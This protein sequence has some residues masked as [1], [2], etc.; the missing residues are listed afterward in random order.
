MIHGK[1]WVWCGDALCLT[2]DEELHK[3]LAKMFFDKACTCGGT[4]RGCALN[5]IKSISS[6]FEIGLWKPFLEELHKHQS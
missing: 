1:E 2:K 5:K 6:D 3:R 4:G